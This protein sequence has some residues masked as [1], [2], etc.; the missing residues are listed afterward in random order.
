[1]KSAPPRKAKRPATSAG[2]ADLTALVKAFKQNRDV[3]YGGKGFGSTALKVNGR[4]FAM[5]SSKGRFVVKLSGERV[6]EL[7]QSGKGRYFEPARGRLMK[8]WLV[9]KLPK[10]AWLKLAREACDFVRR[11]AV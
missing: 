9:V 10:S 2:D 7:V 4:I 5:L 1:M 3:T 6:D 11:G 8:E